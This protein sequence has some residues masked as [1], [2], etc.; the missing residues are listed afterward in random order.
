MVRFRHFRKVELLSKNKADKLLIILLDR[1][2][3]RNLH[4]EWDL[5]AVVYS[6]LSF[7]KK[8]RGSYDKFKWS[9]GC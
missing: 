3:N 2:K 5:I 9:A 6:A 4:Y 8:E 1:A 7:L